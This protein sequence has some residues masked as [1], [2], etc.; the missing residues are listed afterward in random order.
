MTTER[1]TLD[2]IIE[3]LHGKFALNNDG[4]VRFHNEVHMMVRLRSLE[5][6]F[7][8]CAHTRENQVIANR[9]D[10]DT[11]SERI[12]VAHDFLEVRGG[13]IDD[14]RVFHVGNHQFLGIRLNE[15]Q[16]VVVGLSH[17]AIVELHSQIRHDSVLVVLF[18]NVH[19]ESVIIGQSRN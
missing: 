10:F 1:R 3:T 15:S 14:G 4:R 11:V 19:G 2:E 9:L 17:I 5:L 16:L 8:K 6:R 7:G 12:E 18:V 13:Q